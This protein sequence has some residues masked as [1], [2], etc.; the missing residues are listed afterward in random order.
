VPGKMPRPGCFDS[1]F[2]REFRPRPKWRS[3]SA[4]GRNL[5]NCRRVQIASAR[6]VPIVRQ[7][8]HICEIAIF[9]YLTRGLPIGGEVR[10]SDSTFRDMC[11]EALS[12]S[13]ETRTRRLIGRSVG[14]MTRVGVQA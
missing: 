7:Y 6:I 10:V 2:R 11:A 9:K 5:L 3:T 8:S 14:F 1:M 4:N 12:N 13:S